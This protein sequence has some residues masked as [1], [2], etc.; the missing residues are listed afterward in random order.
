[1]L[2]DRFRL[3]GGRWYRNSYLTFGSEAF[4]IS[5]RPELGT[6]EASR[7]DLVAIEW[8]SETQAPFFRRLDDSSVL[9]QGRWMH[10][11]LGYADIR[12]TIWLRDVALLPAGWIRWAHRFGGS[13][14]GT[15][16]VYDLE[17]LSTP[18]PVALAI[19]LDADPMA[20]HAA[21]ERFGITLPKYST[22]MQ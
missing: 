20:V 2:T 4:S 13:R 6:L 21:I 17:V 14:F 8:Y 19:A 12:V 1:M 7:S 9:D 10:L 15:S 5:M 11:T 18:G 22:R 16:P 3:D